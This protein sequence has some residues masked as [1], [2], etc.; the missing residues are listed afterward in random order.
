MADI[1]WIILSERSIR[2]QDTGKLSIIGLTE[3]VRAR[4]LPF[5]LPKLFVN[6]RV[7]GDPGEHVEITV[8]IIQPDGTLLYS[9]T[10]PA[11]LGPNAVTD[12]VRFTNLHFGQRGTY[13]V[14]A[15]IG[16]SAPKFVSLV[17]ID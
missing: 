7:I 3:A 14:R 2:E 5:I 9:G 8:A 1:D 12:Y 6:L 11:T 17:L 13:E 16:D 15:S 10:I 4:Q